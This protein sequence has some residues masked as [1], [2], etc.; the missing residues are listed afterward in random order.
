MKSE[1]QR[2]IDEFL[3]KGGQV[4]RMERG[5]RTEITEPPIMRKRRI[6]ANVKARAKRP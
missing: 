3:A 2:L 1:H 6:L 5:A 4:R